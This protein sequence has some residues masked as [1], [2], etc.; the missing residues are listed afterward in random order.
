MVCTRSCQVDKLLKLLMKYQ[1]STE[2]RLL[3]N[4]NINTLIYINKISIYLYI[5][6]A[7]ALISTASGPAKPC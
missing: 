5:F 1:L 7:R 6:D 2:F 3:Y 4:N